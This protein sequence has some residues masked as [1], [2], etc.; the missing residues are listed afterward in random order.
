MATGGKKNNNATED[1]KKKL[2]WRKK[3]RQDVRLNICRKMV[4]VYKAE[5]R[6]P[7]ETRLVERYLQGRLYL[8]FEADLN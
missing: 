7:S 1:I 3:N 6:R 2:H 8:E 5:S 4:G